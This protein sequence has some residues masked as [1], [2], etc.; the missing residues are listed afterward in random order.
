MVDFKILNQN[1]QREIYLWINKDIIIN[2]P[3]LK[4]LRT[5]EVMTIVSKLERQ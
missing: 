5:N 2:I 4:T 3:F 1:L